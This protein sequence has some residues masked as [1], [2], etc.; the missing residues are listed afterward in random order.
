MKKLIRMCK[1]VQFILCFCP[2]LHKL[3]IYIQ[4]LHVITYK[5]EFNNI[6]NSCNFFLSEFEEMKSRIYRVETAHTW[7]RLQWIWQHLFILL[8]EETV[9]F[10]TKRVCKIQFVSEICNHDPMFTLHI[11][12][13]RVENS[14]SAII[15][16]WNIV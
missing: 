5:R 9:L 7:V 16:S 4:G 14:K 11:A 15:E 1:N 3:H 13:L 10:T 12:G 6:V 8:L 2:F